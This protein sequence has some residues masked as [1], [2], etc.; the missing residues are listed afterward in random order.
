MICLYNAHSYQLGIDTKSKA[1]GYRE[2]L[3]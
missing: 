1:L 3:S 2:N